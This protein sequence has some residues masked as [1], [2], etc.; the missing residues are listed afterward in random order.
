MDAFNSLR[1]RSKVLLV[2]SGLFLLS[3]SVSLLVFGSNAL[4]SESHLINHAKESVKADLL[5]SQPG[6]HGSEED[7]SGH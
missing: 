5:Y 6:A 4:T 7:E 3:L 1:Q 2:A